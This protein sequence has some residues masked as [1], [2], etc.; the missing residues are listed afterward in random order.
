MFILNRDCGVCKKHKHVL[1]PFYGYFN[2]KVQRDFLICDKCAENLFKK[3][4][5]AESLRKKEEN[6]LNR[7]MITPKRIKN[8]LDDYV[9]GQ[10]RAK[11]TLSVA[12]YNHIKSTYEKNEYSDKVIK[13]N[14]ILLIGPTGVGK[15]CLIEVLSG[16]LGL[17]FV[18][19]D[20]TS[21]TE[22]GYTGQN[23]EYMVE[24]LAEAAGFDK[25]ETE[26][27][28]IFVDE[29]DKKAKPS[30]D[31]TRDVSGE[32]VQ[33]S[34]LKM[35]EG[36][37]VKVSYM[38]G[39]KKKVLNIDTSGI[40]FVFVGAFSGLEEV[41]MRRLNNKGL[42]FGAKVMKN[43]QRQTQLEQVCA[44]D[45][46]RY[47]LIPELVGRMPIVSVLHD[48]G[49]DDMF[50]IL[51]FTK[52]SPILQYQ[53]LF[54]MSGCKLDFT[55]EALSA[56]AEKVIKLGGGA[57]NLS[58]VIQT[59]LEPLMFEFPGSQKN[60]LIDEGFVRK[61]KITILNEQDECQE[62]KFSIAM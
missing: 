27:G 28:I 45:L 60:I 23:V 42:G 41:I 36:K 40:L 4:N 48:L 5:C 11:T 46:V 30:H 1:L 54:D 32:G 10:D 59:L 25:D 15:T 58:G 52:K 33:R 6:V 18:I 50:N 9:V 8:Y 43:V 26:K 21:M 3:F 62:I 44:E 22:A 35:A 12:V 49:V 29:I 53:R 31:Y 20:S 13:K 7:K 57:R 19:E 2:L 37:T 14:N 34:L 38:E 56:I 61:N 47:G 24:R 51:K 55:D 17:P 39:E 16:F